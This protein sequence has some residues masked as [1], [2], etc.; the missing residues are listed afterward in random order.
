MKIRHKFYTGL[1]GGLAVLFTILS[2]AGSPAANAEQAPEVLIETSIQNLLNE[3]THRRDEL[4]QDNGKL[5]AL[6]DER[7]VPNFDL[8]LISKA[9]LARSWR[10]ASEAQRSQFTDEF[11]KLLVRTYAT[12]L[13]QYTGKEEMKFVRT[14]YNEKKT[15]AVVKTEVRLSEGPSVPVNYKL[16]KR[17][18]GWKVWDIHIDG[19]SLVINYKSSY[20]RIIKRE[21]LDGLISQ[22]AIKNSQAG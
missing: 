12:A 13:F 10:K 7:V 18:S 20:A 11:R 14:N 1:T 3:F 8:N 5:Y 22:L 15:Q 6:V 2:V 19:I 17:E 4:A 16:I 21:G 9:V